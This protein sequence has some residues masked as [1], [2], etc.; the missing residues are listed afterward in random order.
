MDFETGR[1]VQW[2]DCHDSPL[3]RGKRGPEH[4]QL[5]KHL[6]SPHCVQWMRVHGL[7]VHPDTEIAPERITLPDSA[8]RHQLELDAVI[9]PNE[10]RNM[11]EAVRYLTHPLYRLRL[12]GVN[13][14]FQTASPEG[15]LWSDDGDC[16]L[17]PVTGS[18]KGSHWFW[19]EGG[20]AL[21]ITPSWCCDQALAS[22]NL[23]RVVKIDSEAL[24]L[25]LSVGIASGGGY[26][27]RWLDLRSP[28]SF[29]YGSYPDEW[30]LGADDYARS[31]VVELTS[32]KTCW[33]LRLRWQD[34]GHRSR[35]IIETWRGAQGVKAI[36][37]PMPAQI[38]D[39]LLRFRVQA[40]KAAASHVQL[41][42]LWSDCGRFLVLQP[43][44]ARAANTFFVLD[45]QT[46]LR[47]DTPYSVAG[48]QLQA[49][50]YGYLQVQAPVA[51][52]PYRY[53]FGHF[54]PI[55]T[56]PAPNADGETFATENNWLLME[57]QR[58][59]LDLQ[60]AS[61]IGP[62]PALVQVTK[63]PYPNAAFPY[64]Y[65][66]PNGQH[67]VHCFSARNEFND[68]YTRA[69]ESRYQACAI[70]D[71][72]VCLEGLGVAMIWSTDSRYLFFT[73]RLPRNH[74]DFKDTDWKG[75]LLDIQQNQ[76]HGPV[77]LNGLAILDEFD[78]KT[79]KWRRI[80]SDWWREDLD[81]QE[82]TFRL[83]DL[84]AHP[85]QS[86]KNYHDLWLG[87]HTQ[88]RAEW[89]EHYQQSC[90]I[91]SQLNKPD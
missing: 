82:K 52:V 66:S 30:V 60:T 32:D 91:A 61:I 38:G 58:F 59:Q 78:S 68:S 19:K 5:R 12:N 54:E 36:F 17:I 35:G 70:T 8:N 28:S 80:E 40:G 84:L 73:T 11:A 7:W 63:P 14:P 74:T 53:E 62:L 49:Y 13:L 24:Y 51:S 21:W 4:P 43:Y 64:L 47:M 65:A 22:A 88:H 72:G 50:E 71:G 3:L 86:L 56:A 15:I 16:L 2:Q 76:I 10:L 29:T 48:L 23:D 83:Q 1:S 41:F 69:Q 26:P 33:Q 34:L 39:R 25:S 44:S 79:L 42:H 20:E 45:T 87:P 18:S 9:D 89:L 31:N 77:D 55:N 46:G 27:Q 81:T 75:W 6:Q 57:S 85:T 90:A 37:E 67:W